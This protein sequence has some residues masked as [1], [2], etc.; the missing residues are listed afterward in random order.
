M[1]VAKILKETA[2]EVQNTPNR[3]RR[4]TN[5]FSMSNTYMSSSLSD[6]YLPIGKHIY[7]YVPF[8]II[9]I[10]ELI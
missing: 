3:A 2:P 8:H 5:V 4:W 6:I 7:V 9:N 1:W 10:E